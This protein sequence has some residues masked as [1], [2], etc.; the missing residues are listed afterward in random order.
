M[1]AALAERR[2]HYPRAGQVLQILNRLPDYPRITSMATSPSTA[3]AAGHTVIMEKFR[4][5]HP[6]VFDG[7]AGVERTRALA[8]QLAGKPGERRLGAPQNPRTAVG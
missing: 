4:R 5:E 2:V 3:I 8:L 1:R 7:E 6:P